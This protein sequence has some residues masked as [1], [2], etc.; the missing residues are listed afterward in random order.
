MKYCLKF[1][2]VLLALAAPLWSLAQRD[3]VP[4]I[5]SGMM[6]WA[7]YKQQMGAPVFQQNDMAIYILRKD[8]LGELIS[9][10]ENAGWIKDFH[11]MDVNGDRYLDAFYC[12]S[13]KARGGHYTYFMRADA[14]LNY[15]I[16]LQAPGYV[17]QLKGDP[18]GL[19]IILRSDAHGKGYLHTVTEYYYYFEADSLEM[20]WQLQMVSTT[21]VPIMRSPTAFVLKTP[22]QLRTTPKLS[23]EPPVDYD[24]DDKY[25]G[26]GNIVAILEPGLRGFKLAERLVDG[27]LWSFVTVFDT[28][29]GK[30]LFKPVPNAQMAYAGWIL[31]QGQS[32]K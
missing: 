28:P 3:T 29:R 2:L 1:G 22:N 20:G 6:D 24:Q 8:S 10:E 25:D 30:H 15:P 16:K 18:K 7:R 11:F 14:G 13:T 31:E 5:V 23:N 27:N 4:H 32:G 9:Q 21:E 17:H 12:G 26:A 19:E